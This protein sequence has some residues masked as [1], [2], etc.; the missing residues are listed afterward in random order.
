MFYCLLNSLLSLA[1]ILE[2]CLGDSLWLVGVD[3]FF[4]ARGFYL[5]A[6][7]LFF[8]NL[9]PPLVKYLSS[10]NMMQNIACKTGLP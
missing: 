2:D 10:L 6:F 1:D 3:V 8:K 4:R 5:S 7:C 9:M